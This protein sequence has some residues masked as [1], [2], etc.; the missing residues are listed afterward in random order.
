MAT[1]VSIADGNFTSAST[2]GTCPVSAFSESTTVAVTTSNLDS[3][4]SIPGAVTLSGIALK[5]ATRVASPTGTMTVTLRN[6]T[7]GSD[8][9]SVVVNNSDIG[10]G[11]GWHYFK[12]SSN[13]LLTAGQSYIV[14]VSSSVSSQVTLYGA[15]T[16]N[17][18]RLFVSTATAAP[19]AGDSFHVLGELTGAG[20]GNNRTVT[21]DATVDA[22][23][24]NTAIPSSVGQRG[25]LTWATSSAT[26]YVLG[27]AGI[28]EITVGGTYN[29]GTTGTPCPRDSTMKLR[30]RS[31]S[32]ATP[33][34]YL[35]RRGG[36]IVMQG[37]SRTS[38]KNIVQ[39]SLTSDLSASGTTLNVD[40]D[41]GWLSGDE[42]CITHTERTAGQGEKRTLSGNAGATSM[43]ITSGVTN[44]HSASRLFQCRVGLLTRNVLIENDNASFKA[45]LRSEGAT[46]TVDCDW[47]Q[48][49]D[50]NS[51]LSAAIGIVSPCQHDFDFCS[52]TDAHS[53]GFQVN[54]IVSGATTI[55]IRNCVVWNHS[56]ASVSASALAIAIVNGFA[57]VVVTATDNLLV[58]GTNASAGL[59]VNTPSIA[60]AVTG[61]FLAG[62]STGLSFSL[63]TT[64]I[65]STTSIDNNTAVVCGTGF[66]LAPCD[67]NQFTATNIKAYHCTANGI[68]ISGTRNF[69][70]TNAES[71][72]NATAGLLL[73]AGSTS[74]NSNTNIA[75][76]ATGGTTGFTQP[77]G[78]TIGNTTLFNVAFRDTVFSSTTGGKTPST[79]EVSWPAAIT[80]GH[81]CQVLF[82]NAVKQA[83]LISATT[84]PV[85][86]F[87]DQDSY[88]SFSRINGTTDGTGDYSVGQLG[89][90]EYDASVFKTAAPSLKMSSLYGTSSIKMQSAPLGRRQ[91]VKVAAGATV[92]ASVWTRTT[93]TY[94]GNQ[95]RLMVAA[96]AAAG[97][98]SDTALDTMTVGTTTW[99][100]LSGTTA[101]VAD[102][103][104]LEFYVDC[105]G[106]AGSVNVDDWNI[107]GKTNDLSSWVN[108]LPTTEMTGSGGGGSTIILPNKL[109]GIG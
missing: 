11:L 82:A 28:L 108:G 100:Q 71:F 86:L 90:L 23:Y 51:L 36:T 60:G 58:A 77:T 74:Y 53:T 72:G 61:N 101:T 24:G 50:G 27:H 35:W 76:F 29:Q 46:G 26:N 13:Q 20:T 43:T 1:L 16:T 63:N 30:F 4:S 92:T 93:G 37:Q 64:A 98:T 8:V 40:T 41:T 49:K 107:G 68:V 18:A 96:N 75:N 87:W 104:E 103:C 7:L 70:L 6:T 55:G 78:V 99:E 57:G 97:I 102:D 59:S 84:A 67:V 45:G 21:M 9:T 81:L 44:A 95:P 48:F 109:N 14:R 12:F 54:S 56:T 34:A 66:S 85:T 38:G 15:T 62:F 89:T 2:W 80:P 42:I 10:N 106:T 25:T 52:C 19:V 94:N 105:D 22:G 33:T 88:I 73:T 31:T 3:L 17:I 47:V 65:G 69:T 83:P 39:C 5:I 91:K 32:A 79:T